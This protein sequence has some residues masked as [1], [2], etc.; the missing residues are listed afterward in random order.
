MLFFQKTA[1]KRDRSWWE[2]LFRIGMVWRI[3]YGS[4]RLIVGIFFL[5]IVGTP[6]VD[7][8][9]QVMRREHLEDP[10]DLLIQVAGPALQ[11]APLTVTYFLAGYLIFWGVIDVVLSISLIKEKT[12][13]FPISMYLIG[14]FVVYEFYRFLHTHSLILLGVIAVDVVLFYLIRRE[15][16]VLRSKQHLSTFT[17]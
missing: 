8:F 12:W 3:F 4:V 5:R 15:Y 9:Y 2:I 16:R 14:I 10:T 13:A 1:E 6:L 11:H 7:V 17:Y